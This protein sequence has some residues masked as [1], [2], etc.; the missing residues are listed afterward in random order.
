MLS[1]KQFF[2]VV[3][4]LSFACVSTLSL[5]QSAAGTIA[6]IVSGM[7]HFPNDSQ[8]A[9]LQG[10]ASDG[11]QSEAIQTI[12]QA[13]HDIQHTVSEDTRAK[14]QAIAGDDSVDANTRMLA[15]V[16]AG[17]NH[18]ASE[19]DEMMLAEID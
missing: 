11:S 10:I 3:A 17:F 9:T 1:R 2:S 13:V 4:G 7:N 8:K 14:L 19:S 5:A 18:M 12:A 16:V 6:E 15:E